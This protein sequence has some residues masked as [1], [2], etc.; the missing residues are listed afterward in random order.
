MA[1]VITI[2]F[3]QVTTVLIIITTSALSMI[4]GSSI[5]SR[6]RSRSP[7]LNENTDKISDRK[8]GGGSRK[9]NDSGSYMLLC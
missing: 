9:I 5:R 4:N 8:I 2:T 7:G 6:N 3:A 1:I